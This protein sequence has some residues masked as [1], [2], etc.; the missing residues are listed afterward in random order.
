MYNETTTIIVAT[1]ENV[2]NNLIDIT[3]RFFSSRLEAIRYARDYNNVCVH[4]Y[5]IKGKTL[6]NC[7]TIKR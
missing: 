3:S 1:A 7:E 5:Q 4:V 6:K 2:Y